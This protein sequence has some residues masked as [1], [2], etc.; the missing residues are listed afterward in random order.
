MHRCTASCRAFSGSYTSSSVFLSY[1]RV[2]SIFY[3]ALCTTAPCSH[4]ALQI[5]PVRLDT[6]RSRAISAHHSVS[7]VF[8]D[9]PL[10]CCSFSFILFFILSQRSGNG[11]SVLRF[12]HLQYTVAA[13]ICQPFTYCIFQQISAFFFVFFYHFLS[14]VYFLEQKKTPQLIF[15]AESLSFFCFTP[16]HAPQGSPAWSSHSAPSLPFFSGRYTQ[17]KAPTFPQSADES[18]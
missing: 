7:R 13:I 16:N 2:L 1:G 8:S 5:F 10:S 17:W 11:K 6:A 14:I 15:S 9:I 12:F 4:R 3:F 18:S